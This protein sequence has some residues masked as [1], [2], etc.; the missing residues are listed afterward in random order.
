MGYCL[1]CTKPQSVISRL[2]S[3]KP[4]ESERKPRR[5]WAACRCGEQSLLGSIW[6]WLVIPGSAE[7][8]CTLLL[9]AN[10]GASRFTKEPARNERK[11]DFVKERGEKLLIPAVK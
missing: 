3:K 2:H 7:V 9:M 11:T 10:R 5:K 8:E 4:G 6:R 1:S